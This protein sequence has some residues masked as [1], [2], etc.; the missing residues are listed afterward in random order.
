ML[1]ALE[2]RLAAL[3]GDALATRT[4]LTVEQSPFSAAELAVGKGSLRIAVVQVGP[5]LGF[6]RDSQVFESGQRKR[7]MQVQFQA[8]LQE[9]VRPS[10]TTAEAQAAARQLFLEDVSLTLH[11]LDADDVRNGAAFKVALPDPG[12]K[13]RAFQL[14]QAQT[15]AELQDGVLSGTLA[16]DGHTLLWPPEPGE[17]TGVIDAVATTTVALPLQAPS[18]PTVVFA[19]ASVNL[20]V[21]GVQGVRAAGGGALRLFVAVLAD[22]PPAQRG[23]ITNGVAGPEAGSWLVA[24]GAPA[25]IVYQAPTVTA[26]R[27]EYV[28]VSLA[29]PDGTRG[30]YLGT[31]ELEVSPG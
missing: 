9:Q 2:S 10:S 19:G 23:T 26:A 16:Y 5:E 21:G 30:A 4:H 22:V 14:R 1:F 20:T 6:E 7:V 3:L 11:R 8:S 25:V 27:V 13:V 12:F 28:A 31:V 29:R 18:G 17:P 15:T 24:A